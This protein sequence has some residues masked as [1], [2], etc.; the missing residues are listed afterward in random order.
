MEERDVGGYSVTYG[1]EEIEFPVYV[2][3]FLAATLLAATIV[4]GNT[5]VMVLGV[6][7]A[8]ITYSN[9][10]LLERRPTMGANQY[11]PPFSPPLTNDHGMF[12]YPPTT[13]MGE[14][15]TYATAPSLASHYPP[16]VYPPR[17]A[18]P[19]AN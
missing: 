9:V 19:A 16:Y 14:Y 5:V 2:I 15:S 1:R 18:R 7:A 3:A 12:S 8:G 17:S 13:Y 6:A 10:P 11:L 4:W